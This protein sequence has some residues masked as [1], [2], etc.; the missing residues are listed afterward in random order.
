M[1]AAFID[2]NEGRVDVLITPGFDRPFTTTRYVL[3]G[4]RYEPTGVAPY[5]KLVSLIKSQ[6]NTR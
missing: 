2:L 5:D 3:K 1:D 6:F 4:E